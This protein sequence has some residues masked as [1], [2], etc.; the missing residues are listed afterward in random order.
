LP[1]EETGDSETM[2]TE[3]LGSGHYRLLNIP[4]LAFDLSYGD[5]VS[6]EAEEGVLEFRR[7]LVRGGHST[8]RLMLSKDV[9]VERS[10]SY[11]R[12]LADLGCAFELFSARWMAVDVPSGSDIYEVYAVIEEG[13]RQG[14][15]LFDEAHLGH[16]LRE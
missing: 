3:D 12:R 13:Q 9:S 11:R 5:I 16:A 8:Y 4:L 1:D 2:W 14:I 6:A 10:D 15:W 7:V